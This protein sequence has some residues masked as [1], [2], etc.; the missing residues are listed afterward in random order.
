MTFS[1]QEKAIIEQVRSLRDSPLFD[2]IKQAFTSGE[3]Q[4]FELEGRKIFVEPEAPFAG[5][6]WMEQNAFHLGTEAFETDKELLKT[7]LHELYRLEHRTVHQARGI[8]Q[9][10]ATRETILAFE[11]AERALKALQE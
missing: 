9:S 10:S 1:K 2:A 6:T 3:Q 7:L 5:L 4:V 11:F 8:S